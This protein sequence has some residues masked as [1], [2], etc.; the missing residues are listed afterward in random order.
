MTAI[1]FKGMFDAY[2]EA[3]EKEWRYDRNASL[4]ASE[5]FGCHRKAFFRKHQYEPDDDYEQ[6][7]GAAKRGDIIENYFAVPAVQAI[8]PKGADLIMAGE[9][10]DTLREKRL[11]AT[12]D[13]LIIGL[14]RDALKELGIDDIESDSVVIEFK[15]FDPRASI[16][17]AKEIHEGQTQVQMGMIHEKTNHRPEYAVIVYFNA[18]FL[19]D[20]RCF[21]VKRNPKIFEVAKARAAAIFEPGAEPEDFM[22]EGKISGECSMCEFTEECAIATGEATPKSKK[23]VT[24]PEILERLEILSE[25]HAKSA[26]A[27][28]AAEKD[29]KIA[30]EEIK[31]LL[32]EA[33]T[34]SVGEEHFRISLAWCKGKTSLDQ[35]ALAEALREHGLKIEDFQ[36]EGNGYERLTVKMLDP[37]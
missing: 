9:D 22:A 37:D 33:D 36:N 34:K 17:G 19:S 23:K 12:L 11:S 27:E 14:E 7:W 25:R 13:G 1:N 5:A 8:L 10:Q 29:K 21:V 6:D 31:E 4:G 24:D 32:R 30:A 16:D 2:T 28:K 18:S 26:E 15:S 3:V 20:I 35:V